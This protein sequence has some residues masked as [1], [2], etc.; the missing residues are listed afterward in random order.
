MTM[1][2]KHLKADVLTNQTRLGNDEI[3]MAINPETK[4]LRYYDDRVDSSRSC[5]TIDKDIY[6]PVILPL[7]CIMTWSFAFKLNNL[8]VI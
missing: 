2:I 7:C 8:T 4:E 6:F 3:V 5:V 1:F